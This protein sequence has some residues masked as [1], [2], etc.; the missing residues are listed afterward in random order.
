MN[1]LSSNTGTIVT[2]EVYSRLYLVSDIFG[3]LECVAGS[4]ED[5]TDL[6][7]STPIGMRASR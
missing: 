5:P 7:H 6:M 3:Y 1:T 2:T 4:K